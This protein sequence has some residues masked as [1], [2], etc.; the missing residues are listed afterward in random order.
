MDT[1]NA[2]IQTHIEDEKYMTIIKIREVLVDILLDIA[3]DVYGTYVITDR[4]GVKQIIVQ[5]QNEIYST[6]T[7]SL[8]YY[9]NIRKVLE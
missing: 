2:F 8:I 9:K 6:M 1:P 3:P 5:H 4:K 7:A